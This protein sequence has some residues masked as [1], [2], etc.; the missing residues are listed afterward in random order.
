MI[1]HIQSLPCR[2]VLLY[3]VIVAVMWLTFPSHPGPRRPLGLEGGHEFIEGIG[4]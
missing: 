2:R 4:K 1:P 3:R